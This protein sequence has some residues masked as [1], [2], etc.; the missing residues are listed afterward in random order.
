MTDKEISKPVAT[1]SP[2]VAGLSIAAVITYHLLLIALIFIR[3][4]LDPSWHASHNIRRQCLDASSVCSFAYQ[5]ECGP[6]KP[7]MGNGAA[8]T[9][10]DRWSTTARLVG[11]LGAPGHFCYSAGQQRLR[12]GHPH[13]LAP[14]VSLFN[15]HGVVNNPR[16]AG[17]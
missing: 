3:P 2:T 7:S 16:L 17:A 8:G 15:L 10:M 14:S 1:I 12:P 13:W 4:D 5:P 9:A 11:F 6:Q